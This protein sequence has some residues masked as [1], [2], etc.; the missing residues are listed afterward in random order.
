MLL[1]ELTPVESSFY[2]GLILDYLNHAPQ[3]K[4]FY[5]YE[6]S[7][8]GLKEA[9][10][11]REFSP[12]KRKV[13]IQALTSEYK[14][15]EVKLQGAV[16]Q[17]LLLLE[18]NN[19][20]T[21]TTGH[22]LG[23]LTGPLYF[24]GKIVH[25]IKVSN[26]LSA[27]FPDKH[28]VPVFWMAS[29]DH[30]F[31]EIS[32]IDLRG[33]KYKWNHLNTGN[34]VGEYDLS[35]LSELISELKSEIGEIELLKNIEAI[36]T[37]STTLSAATFKLVH[38]L[39]ENYGLL[40]IEPNNPL[41]KKEFQEVM[42]HDILEQK[43]IAALES[44]NVELKK[45]HY[46]R[47]VNG[48]DINFFYLNGLKRELINKTTEGF[49]AGDKVFSAEEM[50]S[51]IISTPERFSPNV[52]LRPVYQET[53]LPNIAYSGGPGELAYWLQLKT[54]FET[55]STQYPVV[56]LRN[57]FALISDSSKHKRLKLGVPDNVYFGRYDRMHIEALK[58]FRPTHEKDYSQEISL[59]Y[60]KM[61]NELEGLDTSL[62]AEMIKLK[63]QHEI[64]LEQFSKQIK[65][66]KLELESNR[67]EQLFSIR[68]ELFPNEVPAERVNNILHYVRMNDHDA[69]VGL[70][71]KNAST[72]TK[73]VKLLSW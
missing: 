61:I 62:M 23:I 60:Q 25:T 20:F 7:E 55:H 54:V 24:I 6:H 38:L 44:A 5:Q 45:L 41:L 50:K 39:F 67:L 10:S 21:V 37:S 28:F 36:I 14:K 2:S 34:A 58:Y 13:L 16:K 66:R 64:Q 35:G 8:E 27:L 12:E 19:T 4:S 47:Q 53:I 69:F 49:K 31:D 40:I 65:K 68:N 70:L 17:N 33:K 52:V 46:H 43:S 11:N 30:D 42:L 51:E 63:K 56:L 57:S 73:S 18:Q 22:Q 3:L 59:I 26:E 71:F 9:V 32:T 1:S 72:I 48:R 29:E 15:N